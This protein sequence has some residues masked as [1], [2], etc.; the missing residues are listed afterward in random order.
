MCYTTSRN[1]ILTYQAYFA[2][3][4]FLLQW[5]KYI[6]NRSFVKPN[7]SVLPLNMLLNKNIVNYI[8]YGYITLIPSDF[9]I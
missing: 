8:A 9:P 6:L 4:S 2:R 7:I 1:E 3:I 5:A